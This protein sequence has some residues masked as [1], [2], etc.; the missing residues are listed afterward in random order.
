MEKTL[1]H[2]QVRIFIAKQKL[3]IGCDVLPTL[4]EKV[5]SLLSQAIHRAKQNKRKTLLGRDF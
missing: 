3:K 1:N 4:E 5:A 2:K